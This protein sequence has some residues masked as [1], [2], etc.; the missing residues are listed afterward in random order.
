MVFFI[1]SQTVYNRI[2]LLYRNSSNGGS[3]TIEKKVRLTH[4][5]GKGDGSST[6]EGNGNDVDEAGDGIQL[7]H[8]ERSPAVTSLSGLVAY[9][10]D[11]SGSED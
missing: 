1:Q 9:S 6:D 5:R 2:A 11:S 8:K 7:H 10:S 3:G 4:E